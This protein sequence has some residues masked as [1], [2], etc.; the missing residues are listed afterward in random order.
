MG[1]AKL[2]GENTI[3]EMVSPAQGKELKVTKVA[4]DN[5]LHVNI[6]TELGELRVLHKKTLNPIS[7]A[8]VK[9]Y[10]QD[11]RNNMHKFFKDGYTDL[12]GRFNF[13]GLSTDQLRSSKPCPCLSRR[14]I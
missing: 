11:I 8:Y 13:R 12:R 9:V 3:V 10:A 6:S 7:K 14:R 5:E 4:Y 2:R 1:P